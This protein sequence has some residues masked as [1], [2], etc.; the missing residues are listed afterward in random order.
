[1]QVC[2]S[3]IQFATFIQVTCT[4]KTRLKRQRRISLVLVVKLSGSNRITLNEV[5][6]LIEELIGVN[7]LRNTVD[8]II[9][10]INNY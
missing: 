8:N 4:M 9:M 1:M 2:S 3:C 6:S 10:Y 7:K 5:T